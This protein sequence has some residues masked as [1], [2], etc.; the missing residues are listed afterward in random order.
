MDYRETLNYIERARGYGIVPGL[1]NIRRLLGELGNPQDS[2]KVV[3]VAGTN[4]KGSVIAF[5]EE[6]L[7]RAGYKVGAY[8]SPAIDDYCE[9]IRINRKAIKREDVAVYY[10]QIRTVAEHMSHEN[11]MQPTLYEMETAMAFMHFAKEKCDIVLLETGMGGRE[12]ATNVMQSVLCSV[13]TSISMD[14]MQFLGDNVRDIAEQKAGIIKEDCPVVLGIQEKEFESDVVG[15]VRE[16]A[17]KKHCRL[18]MTERGVLYNV[19]VR[20]AFQQ[21]NAALAVNTVGVLREKGYVISDSNVTEGL[22]NMRWECRFETI[23]EAPRI[24]LDAA[25]NPSAAKTLA[26]SIEMYFT[27]EFI[28]FIM[29]VL[30]DKDYRGIIER[31]VHLAD[32]I[33]TVT[34]DSPRAMDGG[35]LA[36]EVGRFNAN[37]EYA[38]DMVCA[39]GKAARYLEETGAGRDGVIIVFGS[40][41]YLGA[42]RKIVNESFT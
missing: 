1:E 42:I 39:V 11:N 15:I 5:L 36:D 17:D 21:H 29:G 4:G 31:T 7:V 23:C 22:K 6:I 27:N 30:A 28:V 18:I 37:T 13:L 33:I 19:G 40:L 16:N 9:I 24:V 12:D 14:H 34:P 3:H 26:E 25:H 8:I 38:P 35:A 2:L 32:K 20:G 10:T 41:S